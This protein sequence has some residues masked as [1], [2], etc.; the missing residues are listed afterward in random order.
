MLSE[1]CFVCRHLLVLFGRRPGVPLQNCDTV[2]PLSEERPVGGSVLRPG[3]AWNRW[4]A[5]ILLAARGTAGEGRSAVSQELFSLRLSARLGCPPFTRQALHNWERGK[6]LIPAGVLLAA[7][8]ESQ[9]QREDLLKL[10]LDS[11]SLMSDLDALRADAS[12]RLRLSKAEADLG[13][14]QERDGATRHRRRAAEAVEGAIG[15]AGGRRDHPP[16]RG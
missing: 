14:A 4:A 11:R 12:L 8:E 16:T 3:D 6:S 9:L 10:S 1:H 5:A 2:G 7:I 13:L 15:G